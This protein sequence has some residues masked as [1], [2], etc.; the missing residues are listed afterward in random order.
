MTTLLYD[1]SKL[2]SQSLSWL[3]VMKLSKDPLLAGHSRFLQY[4]LLPPNCCALKTV[5]VKRSF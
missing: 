3:F 5:I 2:V 4:L 1:V